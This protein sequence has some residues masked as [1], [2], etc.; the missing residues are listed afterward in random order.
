MLLPGTLCD[1]RIFAP[2]RQRLASFQTEVILT[3]GAVSLEEAAEQVLAQAPEHFA[4]LGFSLGGMIALETALRAPAR[5]RSLILLSTTPLP[6]PAERHAERR[7]AVAGARFMSM[8]TFID[9]QL[10]PEYGGAPEDACTRPLLMQMADELGHATFASQTE[11][12]LRRSDFRPRLRNIACPAL[13]IAGTADVLCPPYAQQCL[14]AGLA[15]S[16]CTML[17]GAGHFA[18]V[19]QPDEVASAVA[20]WFHTLE[21]A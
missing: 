5:V 7:A 21:A 15:Q 4:L 19:E 1:A 8:P 13:V 6:V 16:T 12:A 10:W 9:E 11:M 14:A 18:L 3:P 17:S 2:L 20:A